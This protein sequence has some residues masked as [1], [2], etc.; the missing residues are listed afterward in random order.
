MTRSKKYI[1]KKK[2]GKKQ[3]KDKNPF[4]KNLCVGGEGDSYLDGLSVGM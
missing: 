4:L 3:K 2:G 1:I